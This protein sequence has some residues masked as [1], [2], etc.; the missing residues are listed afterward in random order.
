[1]TQ[2]GETIAI[3]VPPSEQDECL[4]SHEKMELKDRANVFPPAGG[5]NDANLLGKNMESD[6]ISDT[7]TIIVNDNEES[8]R[9]SPHHLIPGDESWPKTELKKWV[10]KSLDHIKENIGYDVNHPTNGV[11]LP[12]STGY[13]EGGSPWA[14]Y[15]SK[16]DYARAA[17]E[18][19]SAQFHDRHVAYSRFVVKCLDKISE[20]LDRRTNAKLSPGCDH[21]HCMGQ[22]ESKPYNPPYELVPRLNSVASRLRRLLEGSPKNWRMPVFTSR[23]ALVYKEG[24]TEKEARTKLSA[25]AKGLNKK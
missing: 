17:M 10:D 15:G 13:K 8:L 24:L 19:T 2:V 21:E 14:G 7:Q 11:S 23:W 18:A 12:G 25:V 3:V 20:R 1:M 16:Q 6:H 4:F 5:A 9:N 22:D